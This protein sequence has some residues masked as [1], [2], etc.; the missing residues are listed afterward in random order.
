MASKSTSPSWVNGVTG[1]GFRPRRSRAG[2]SEVDIRRPF[3]AEALLSFTGL[4]VATLGSVA[5]TFPKVCSPWTRHV[6]PL[7]G[8]IVSGNVPNYGKVRLGGDHRGRC[9]GGRGQ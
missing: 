5:G 4:P 1:A 7:E 2:S 8:L 3:S 9:P 6:N